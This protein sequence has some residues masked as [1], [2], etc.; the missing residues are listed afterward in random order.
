MAAKK[1]EKLSLKFYGP[2]AIIT[3]IRLVAYKLQL[4]TSSTIHPVF[5]VSQLRRAKGVAISFPV[6]PPQ[7]SPD[8]EMI[9]ESDDV[10]GVRNV[11][12]HGL[13]N[14]EMLIKWKDLPSFEAT[15]ERCYAISQ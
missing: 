10:L 3:R 1:N 15:W 9:V 14:V 7:L 2:F 4:P 8:L 11:I 5:Q 12:S 13:P 6:L